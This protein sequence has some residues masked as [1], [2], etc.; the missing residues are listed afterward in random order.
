MGF[1]IPEP[2]EMTKREWISAN[3]K[4][5]CF[6]N[7]SPDFDETLKRFASF[8]VIIGEAFFGTVALVC[9]S[10]LEM[11]LAMKSYIGA[12]RE[13]YTVPIMK[14][15]E[16]GVLPKTYEIPEEIGE[17]RVDPSPDPRDSSVEVAVSP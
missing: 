17:E 11:E 5:I 3:G 2:K 12:N 15:V 10:K 7:E 13:W 1:Y 9:V 14:L 6:E 4:R 8:P 16:L